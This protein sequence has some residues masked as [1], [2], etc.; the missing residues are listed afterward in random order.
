MLLLQPMPAVRSAALSLLVPA[1]SVYEQPARNG[2]AALLCDLVTRGAGDRD[3]RDL[4][5]AF[6]DLGVQRHESIASEHVAFS[7][8]T[9][10]HN[11]T[12]TLEL[13][14]D[15]ALRPRLPE[16]EFEPTRLGVAQSLQAIEDDPRQKVML[17]LRRRC[18]EDPWGR[19]SDGCLADLP[20]VTLED[21]REHH[22]LCFRPNGSILGIAGSF[23]PDAVTEQVERLFGDWDGGRIPTIEPG[24]EMP[25][26]DHL[27][28]DSTQTQIGI[29]YPSVPYRD[30]DYYTAWAAVSLLSGGTSSRLWNEVREKRGLVYAVSASLSSLKDRAHVLC[31]AGTTVERSQETLEVMF[32]EIERLASGLEAGELERCKARA[33]TALVMQQESSVARAGAVARDWYHLGRVKPLEDVREKVEAITETDVLGFLAENP[34]GD[35]TV[36]TIGP[37][38]PQLDSSVSLRRALS[39]ESDEG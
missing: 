21:V 18:W 25:S 30:P 3:N 23:D 34:P 16:A 1:G 35:Y 8:A 33:K 32:A 39:T 5:T 9:V 11:L 10:S 26:L 38:P 19:P 28:Y 36:V 37:E 27:D 12:A 29:G 2:T 14:A 20:S 13:Y 22:A 7:A 15:V 17:E 6:D 4:S 24:P 31:Y